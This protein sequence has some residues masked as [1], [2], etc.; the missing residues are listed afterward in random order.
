MPDALERAREAKT[1]LGPPH[2]VPFTLKDCIETA[3]LPM[4]LGSKLFQG[5]DSRQ[6]AELFTCLRGAGGILLGKPNMPEFA[7][8]WETDNEVCERTRN[9]W[10]L[11]RTAGGSSGGEVS[12]IAAGLSPLGLGTD[13]AAP[14]GLPLASVAWWESSPTL[15][16]IP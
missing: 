4:T 9:P 5:Y 7:L 1:G 2:G 16:R 3:R 11:G 8:W 15:G 6:D 12:A 13:R 10:N 14:S